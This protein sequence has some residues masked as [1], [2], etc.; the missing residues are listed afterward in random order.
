MRQSTVISTATTDTKTADFRKEKK[1]RVVALVKTDDVFHSGISCIDRQ[2]RIQAN[3]S[4]KP[5][6]LLPSLE[7]LIHDTTVADQIELSNFN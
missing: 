7:Q 5:A 6:V 2:F 4:S 1:R 3:C